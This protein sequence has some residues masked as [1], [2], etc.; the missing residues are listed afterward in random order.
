MAESDR[1]A[2]DQEEYPGLGNPFG[3]PRT[4]TDEE[5]VETIEE[6]LDEG[7]GDLADGGISIAVLSD[8]LE[9]DLKSTRDRINELLESGDVVK[10]DGLTP[11]TFRPRKSY[12]PARDS[13]DS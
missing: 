8:R 6:L 9:Y 12:V 7:K 10:V 2:Q 5:I 4:H 3:R 13:G 1:S 11:E